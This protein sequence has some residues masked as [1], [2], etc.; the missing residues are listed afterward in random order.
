MPRGN[1]NIAAHALAANIARGEERWQESRAHADMVAALNAAGYRTLADLPTGKGGA[2]RI[3]RD[4]FHAD[5]TARMQKR[6]GI[7]P[8]AQTKTNAPAA[9]GVTKSFVLS[10]LPDT[11]AEALTAVKVVARLKQHSTYV[12]R[13]RRALE[14]LWRDGV[15]QRRVDRRVRGNDEYAYWQVAA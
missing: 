1:P 5:W 2:D 6:C 8:L 12:L 10:V 15:L 9:E 7:D 4:R 14:R 11:P 3:V 13:T